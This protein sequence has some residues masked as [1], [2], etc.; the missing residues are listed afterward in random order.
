[1][2]AASSTRLPRSPVRPRGAG[3]ILLPA[4]ALTIIAAAASPQGEAAGTESS[5]ASHIPTAA[6]DATRPV[7]V[8]DRNDID[9]S[10]MKNV[11]DLLLS[12]LK[13]N[14]FGLFRPFVLGSGRTAVLVNGRRV[15]DSG[16]DLDALPISAVERIEILSDSAAAMHG[17]HAIGGAVNIVLRRNDEGVE[18]QV[19]AGASDRSR[20][21]RRARQRPVGRPAWRRSCGSRRGRLPDAGDPQRG[22]RLQPCLV[23]TGRLVRR[24]GRR[25]GGRQHRV[26]LQQRRQLDCACPRRLPGKRVHRR[27]RRAPEHLREGLRI[28]LGRHRVEYGAI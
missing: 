25:F 13:Y 1:M 6:A 14:S 10:G 12:R 18:V 4:A 15:S 2:N 20:R 19:S 3:G 23:D 22:S 11:S 21:R 8:I 16:F 17:G 5:V 26:H 28:R 9:L 27:A 24:H 7:A